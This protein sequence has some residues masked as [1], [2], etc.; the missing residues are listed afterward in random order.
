MPPFCGPQF[1][2]VP[3]PGR[4]GLGVLH[5]STGACGGLHSRFE[6]V[7]VPEGRRTRICAVGGGCCWL[8]GGPGL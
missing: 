5:V 7:L 1:R 3:A 6:F 2:V 8:A 4:G